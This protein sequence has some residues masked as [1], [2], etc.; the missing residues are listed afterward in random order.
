M[1]ESMGMISKAISKYDCASL[2]DRNHE[3]VDQG[4]HLFI[5][6]YILVG[7]SA[8]SVHCSTLHLRDGRGWERESLDVI[9][10][11]FSFT[12][13]LSCTDPPQ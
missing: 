11:V 7:E 2:Y 3:N 6:A 13:F 1:M 4:C 8:K 9:T 5:F 10:I 12:F